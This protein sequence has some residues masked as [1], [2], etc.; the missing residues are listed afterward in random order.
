LGG[1]GR[2]LSYAGGLTWKLTILPLLFKKRSGGIIYGKKVE[3]LTPS[4]MLS[5]TENR[6]KSGML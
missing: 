3:V 6:R 4:E 5:L 1:G 2:F